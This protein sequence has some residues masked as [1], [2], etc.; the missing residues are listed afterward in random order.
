MPVYA[1]APSGCGVKVENGIFNRELFTVEDGAYSFTN[2]FFLGVSCARPGI[3]ILVAFVTVGVTNLVDGEI[4]FYHGIP[5]ALSDKALTKERL[6]T[7]F[8][9]DNVFNFTTVSVGELNGRWYRVVRVTVEETDFWVKLMVT[10]GTVR[11]FVNVTV[12][13]TVLG[14]GDYFGVRMQEV[15]NCG[16]R[17][18]EGDG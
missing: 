12:M 17:R 6:C 2:G 8:T 7:G 3:E 4:V 14:D 5:K 18:C 15:I 13:I 9:T 16:D 11:G 1:D 10:T